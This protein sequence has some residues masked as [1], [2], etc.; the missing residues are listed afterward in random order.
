LSSLSF[1]GHYCKGVGAFFCSALL[2]S[3]LS[4]PVWS[5]D[6]SGWSDKT[7]CRLMASASGNADY[8]AEA[9]RRK[10]DCDSGVSAGKKS[11][12][13]ISKQGLLPKN[14]GI[15]FY[16]LKLDP[17]VKQQLLANPIDKTA[18]DFNPYQLASLVNPIK[19]QFNLRRVQ[20][21]DDVKGR[22]EHW[23]MANGN[24]V[25]TNDG[26]KINGNWRMKGLSKD[27][28]YLK[29]EVNLKLTKAGHLV[30]K[31][32]YFHLMVNDG[33]ALENPVYVNFTPHQRSKPLDVNNLNKGELWV[34]VEDWAGGVLY[35]KRCKNISPS[36]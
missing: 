32:A 24:M 16:P 18:F 9:K 34:D 23:D 12:K 31:M 13:S 3:L 19:C 25:L 22:V 27:P 7:L 30:G 26:A 4:F 1:I 11:S 8:L 33:E 10:L 15:V 17:K 28:S 2:A 6:M 20:Y 14:K 21:T 29:H 5:A 36:S 35:L